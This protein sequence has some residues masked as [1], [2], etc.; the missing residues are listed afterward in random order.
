M[1]REI[2]GEVMMRFRVRDLMSNVMQQEDA[3]RAAG[4][5][6]QRPSER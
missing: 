3:A 4:R 6:A 2:P 1:N 5:Y